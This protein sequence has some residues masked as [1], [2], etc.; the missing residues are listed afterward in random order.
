M[1]VDI[2]EDLSVLE[3]FRR[4]RQWCRL[5]SLCLLLDRYWFER[6]RCSDRDRRTI[7]FLWVWAV[8]RLWLNVLSHLKLGRGRFVGATERILV[9]VHRHRNWKER[10]NVPLILAKHVNRL[11]LIRQTFTHERC[12]STGRFFHSGIPSSI[13]H[14]HKMDNRG[15]YEND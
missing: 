4:Y 7:D 6:C 10:Q 5:R 3:W 9:V 12:V 11:K 13:T 8:L 1:G 14:L 2:L 15:G